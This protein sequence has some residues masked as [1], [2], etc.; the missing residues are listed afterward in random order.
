MF[1][2]NWIDPIGDCGDLVAIRDSDEETLTAD[3]LS[4]LESKPGVRRDVTE[5]INSY[6]KRTSI[7]RITIRRRE[8]FQD[9][10]E[11]R[12]KKMV[13]RRSSSQD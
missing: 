1:A 7:N 13:Y 4:V 9:Y 8:A 5:K 11:S 3:E 2:D 6:V 10:L 12:R